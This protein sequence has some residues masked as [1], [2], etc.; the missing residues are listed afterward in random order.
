MPT[1]TYTILGHSCINPR[2]YSKYLYTS[3]SATTCQLPSRI[4][5]TSYLYPPHHCKKLKTTSWISIEN[6]NASVYLWDKKG[7]H[8]Y[9]PPPLPPGK[10]K[11]NRG[12]EGRKLYPYIYIYTFFYGILS[13]YIYKSIHI[14][15]INSINSTALVH[16]LDHHSYPSYCLLG[17]H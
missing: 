5:A 11:K 7:V 12:R 6:L 16:E 2:I 13:I 10:K 17:F 1:T 4:S 14:S 3:C 15:N 9:P 8:T